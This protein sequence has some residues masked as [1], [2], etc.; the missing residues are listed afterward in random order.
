MRL[1]RLSGR[2]P[3]GRKLEPRILESV[4][5]IVGCQWGSLNEV[6]R[7]ENGVLEIILVIVSGLRDNRQWNY[8][9]MD[10]M[11]SDSTKGSKLWNE[12]EILDL[13]EL[14][15]EKKLYKVFC[16]VSKSHFSI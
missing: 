1:K 11:W 14:T 10:Q 2:F 3:N 16:L 7:K 8:F 12:E 9:E 13:E 15:K 5:G 6:V 4:Q